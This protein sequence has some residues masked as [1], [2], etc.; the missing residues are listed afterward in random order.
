MVMPAQPQ[1]T[2]KFKSAKRN[3][4]KYTALLSGSSDLTSAIIHMIHTYIH[5]YI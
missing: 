1:I 3:K 5:R 4:P 2:A